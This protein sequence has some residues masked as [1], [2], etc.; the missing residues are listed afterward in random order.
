[1]RLAQY[2]DGP[3]ASARFDIQK[4]AARDLPSPLEHGTLKRRKRRPPDAARRR[5][6]GFNPLPRPHRRGRGTILRVLDGV[7]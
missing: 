5:R 7:S 1:L 2:G 3:R 4:H 6:A